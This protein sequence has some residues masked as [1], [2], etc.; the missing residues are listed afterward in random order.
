M[1]KKIYENRVINAE[2][3]ILS[4]EEQYRYDPE[5]MFVKIYPDGNRY[6]MQNPFAFATLMQFAQYMTYCDKQCQSV[7]IGKEERERIARELNVT[8]S[9]I[10]KRI[11]VLLSDNAMKRVGLGKYLINPYFI[12][13]GSWLAVVRAREE[14]DT[15]R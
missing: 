8:E 7:H 15:R 3:V 4:K 11:T 13:K 6:L 14:Y 12:S 2:G 9:L 5:E 10:I 1:R